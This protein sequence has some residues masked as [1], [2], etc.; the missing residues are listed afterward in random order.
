[1]VRKNLKARDYISMNSVAGYCMVGRGTVRRWIVSGQL[2]SI[3]LPSG[4]SRISVKDFKE[5]CRQNAI[6]IGNGIFLN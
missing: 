4:Q 5:F 6:P 1:M 2:K 3:R